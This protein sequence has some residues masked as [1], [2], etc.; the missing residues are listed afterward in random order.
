MKL[1]ESTLQGRT[2]EQ[3]R[4]AHPELF[5]GMEAVSVNKIETCPT[6]HVIC[7]APDTFQAHN[8]VFQFS[9]VSRIYTR[10]GYD[11]VEFF[12]R[13][14]NIKVVQACRNATQNPNF[15]KLCRQLEA[16][17]EGSRYFTSLKSNSRLVV[18]NGGRRMKMLPVLPSLLDEGEKP[19]EALASE[20]W[21]S[22][23]SR[24][25]HR[26]ED[27]LISGT[28]NTSRVF[29]VSLEAVKAYMDGDCDDVQWSVACN[30]VQRR[31][32]G[33]LVS[34]RNEVFMELINGDKHQL[35]HFRL[36]RRGPDYLALSPGKSVSDERGLLGGIVHRVIDDEPIVVKDASDSTPKVSRP[37]GIPC[38]F[39]RFLGQPEL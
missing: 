28:S 20:T 22:L 36:S 10:P 25:V 38:G 7:R 18:L 34:R 39:H 24:V 16:T 37:D 32:I 21:G 27:F 11:A 26:Q 31:L 5:E 1:V 29:S 9:E 13:Y 30:L 15:R 3:F 19:D 17:I 8:G 4:G 35:Q 14:R 6:I 23:F 2:L 33:L 12:A